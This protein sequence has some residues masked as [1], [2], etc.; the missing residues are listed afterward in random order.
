MRFDLC[1]H[2]YDQYAAPQRAFAARVAEFAEVRAGESVVELGA[3]TGA[4]TRLL[5]AG[6]TTPVRATDAS[7][8]MVEIGR[9]K[10][11]EAEWELLDAFA[12]IIPAASLQVSSGLLQWAHDPLAVLLAWKQAVRPGGRMVHAFPCDPCLAEWRALVQD[13][14]LSWKGSEEWLKIF[15]A[16]G[17]VIT[18]HQLWVERFFFPSALQ[19]VRS[20]HLTGVTGQARLSPGRLRKALR[21][22]DQRH[23]GAR[24][25]AATWAWMAVEAVG[26]IS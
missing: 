4:L 23:R 2:T 15:A 13:A 7:A 17:L 8:A 22:Y 21:D 18:R 20:L 9:R 10:E 24:G 12:Q 1:A 3:G 6:T 5:L 11:P 14:P 19:M 26:A 16:A 25:I